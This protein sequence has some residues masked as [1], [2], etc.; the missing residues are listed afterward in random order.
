MQELDLR[1]DR[2]M[3]IIT[4]G[5]AL[6]TLAD[7]IDQVP[8][9]SYAIAYPTMPCDLTVHIDDPAKVAVLAEVLGGEAHTHTHGG[10]LH[11]T[12]TVTVGPV[13]L[14]LVHVNLAGVSA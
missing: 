8:A 6:R 2:L 3:T 9:F 13:V 5:D 4:F 1:T 11:T 10:H 14:R 12:A 7:R